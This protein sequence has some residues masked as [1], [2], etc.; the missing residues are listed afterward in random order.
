MGACADHSFEPSQCTTWFSSSFW[1]NDAI[2]SRQ[3][4]DRKVEWNLSRK[5]IFNSALYICTN[6]WC[7][8]LDSSVGGA[9]EHSPSY[10]GTE[11]W[12]HVSE[13]ASKCWKGHSFFKPRKGVSFNI[14]VNCGCICYEA[15][16][17]GSTTPL[18]NYW[19]LGV[20][21]WPNDSW[22]LAIG[23]VGGSGVVGC[24]WIR[25]GACVLN[26]WILGL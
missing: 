25:G 8:R 10:W 3:S 16:D 18:W 12:D 23:C 7:R 20:P 11:G 14:W 4:R 19:E 1:V 5:D 9:F 13:N 26:L 24:K 21:Y 22:S 2:F 15:A 17:V 6:L